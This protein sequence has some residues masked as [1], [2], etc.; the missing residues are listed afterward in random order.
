MEFKDYYATL[1]VTKAASEKEVK[2]AYRKLARKHHPDVNP[3]DKAAE[4]K[5]KEINEAYEVLGDPSK[6]KKYDELGAN[7]RMYEQAE[8]QG[9][10]NPFA[11]QW[12]VDFGGGG[13]G[14]QGGGY[15]TMTPEEMEE[16]FGDSN[17]FSDF[18]TTFFGGGGGG[19]DPFA[20]AGRARSGRPRQRQGRD[21]EH[22]IELTLEDAQHGTT[23]R[24]A[25]KHD[26]QTKTVDVRIPAGVN[27]GSK[28]RV[29]GEGEA[30]SG[31]GKPGDLYLRV[32]LAPHGVFERK[33]RDL[34]VK[35]PVPVTT[36]VLGGEADVQTLSGK[37]AR[38][39]IPPT[40]QNGQVFRL[41][42]YGMPAVGKPDEKGDLYARVDVHLPTEL[43]PAE[44]EH[45][46]TLA[47]LTEA[48]AKKHS[49]A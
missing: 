23:R 47:K 45:W 25:M 22:E 7:W 19:A 10:P 20:G 6:R 16:M 42:G 30:G 26:G 31:G 40:T 21:V 34:Y 15:R 1:G 27:D 44:R 11:G 36:A 12:N 41:K 48:A 39:R 9:R 38:L 24:L 28:V 37:P 33:G 35:V 14:G 29:G 13:G 43:T 4:T 2:Q 5:F 8:A 17:P 3:G 18:F 49:A 32:R 46:E